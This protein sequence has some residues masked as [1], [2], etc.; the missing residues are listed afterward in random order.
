[1]IQGLK[2]SGSEGGMAGRTVRHD[3]PQMPRPESETLS[4]GLELL[5][6]RMV[7]IQHTRGQSLNIAER[8]RG[9]WPVDIVILLL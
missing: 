4:P 3:S 6:E 5:A 2:G 1:M 7:V 8:L 9:V